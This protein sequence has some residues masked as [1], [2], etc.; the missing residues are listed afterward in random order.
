VAAEELKKDSCAV[1][2]DGVDDLVGGLGPLEGAGGDV[3]E[4]DSVLERG[5]EVFEGAEDAAVEAAALDLGE[6]ALPL[7]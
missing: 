5:G 7:V 2:A 4:L 1:A 3:P 6:P